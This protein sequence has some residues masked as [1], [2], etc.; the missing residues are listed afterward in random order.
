[1]RE[2]LDIRGL[3]DLNYSAVVGRVMRRHNIARLVRW[4]N[5]ASMGVLV[6]SVIVLCV[7]VGRDILGKITAT[8]KLDSQ[9]TS[10]G[11]AAS[12]NGSGSLSPAYDWN[13]IQLRKPFGVLG[14]IAAPVA[15]APTPPPSPL[16]LSLI[17]TFLT[18]GQEPYAII[19]D[20]KK[21]EQEMFLI[22]D[23]V[24]SQATLKKIYL[25]RVEVERNG[26]LEVLRLDEIAGNAGAGV[27]SSGSDDF[28][29]EEA[30]LDKGLE[31]LPL[32]L[33]QARAVPYFKDGR[34]IGLRLFAI[35][36]GSLY[37][38]VGLKNGD[39]LKTIN[40]NSLGD[41]SQA[42]KLF[43]QLKSERSIGLTL[44]RDKQEREFKYTIR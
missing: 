31:N 34:S 37:E 18:Q 29:I 16:M 2:L 9:L 27:I 28:V 14:R 6:V 3:R 38:K 35:K 5:A 43:E 24:F 17:G 7:I 22:G 10:L 4:V 20:K 32:L 26:K 39:I 12:A 21:N 40:G 25:D 44:E 23:S 1:V 8:S 19:E 36:T 30:E 33:T 41:I 15:A 13:V 11:S 42:L